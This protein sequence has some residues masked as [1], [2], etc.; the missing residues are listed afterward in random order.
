MQTQQYS[1]KIINQI[2]K[3]SFPRET[4]FK[5]PK[6]KE[7]HKQSFKPLQYFTFLTLLHEHDEEW[8]QKLRLGKDE[9]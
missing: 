6:V 1:G 7:A 5:N 3:R 9:F 2:Q 8:G 4:I